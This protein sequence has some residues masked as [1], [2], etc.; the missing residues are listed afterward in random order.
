MPFNRPF[1]AVVT[2]SEFGTKDLGT[3]SLS[4]QQIVMLRHITATGCAV[5]VQFSV[6]LPVQLVKC[7]AFK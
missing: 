2:I 6:E 1:G 5:S 7:S 4:V 3:I